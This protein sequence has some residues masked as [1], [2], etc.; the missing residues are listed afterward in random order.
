MN[1]AFDLSGLLETRVDLPVSHGGPRKAPAPT[2]DPFAFMRGG[3]ATQ[4]SPG[5]LRLMYTF[6]EQS[7]ARLGAQRT[8]RRV[9][10]EQAM[11]AARASSPPSLWVI[12]FRTG[13]YFQSVRQDAGGPL[14]TAHTFVS[15]ENVDT[16]MIE[17]PWVFRGGMTA[18][19]ISENSHE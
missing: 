7:R 10:A 16:F 2:F 15:K 14:D 19:Q 6:N 1:Q 3:R 8:E 17:H 11:E 13:R 9:E 4:F 5:M 12:R 18:V